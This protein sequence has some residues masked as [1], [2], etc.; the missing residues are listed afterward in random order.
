MAVQTAGD[1][2]RIAARRLRAVQSGEPMDAT[3]AADCLDDLNLMI[4]SWNTEGL[5]SFADQTQQV[6]Y[7]V[8][9]PAPG[10]AYSLTVGPGGQI[11]CVRPLTIDKVWVV[12]TTSGNI[13]PQALLTENEFQV[14]IRQK[15]SSGSYPY[16]AWYDAQMLAGGTGTGLGVLWLWPNP[17]LSN[18]A[19]FQQVIRF[20]ALL[21]AF[22]SLSSSV[23][24]LPPGYQEAMIADLAVRIAPSLG[25]SAVKAAAEMVDPTTKEPLAGSLRARLK[26]INSKKSAHVLGNDVP[27][28]QGGGLPNI[29][30]NTTNPS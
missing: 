11:N 18:S 17:N 4:D 28:R 14:E 29:L 30:T 15:P 6:A 19:N 12:D 9:A 13:L 21:A 10:Q 16:Y 2:I 3:V 25:G 5:V 1:L 22:A 7:P 26:A 24:S 27:T 20:R 8:E 23:L